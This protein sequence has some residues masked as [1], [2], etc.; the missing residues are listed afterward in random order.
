MADGSTPKNDERQRGEWYTLPSFM[1]ITDLKANGR[2]L[3][4]D[5]PN[6]L[7]LDGGVRIC[8]EGFDT[9]EPVMLVDHWD[10]RPELLRFPM[11]YQGELIHLR[12]GGSRV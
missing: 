12:R 11:R 4:F 3:V 1:V 10:H 8:V 2:E 6:M 9:D 5:P 7:F